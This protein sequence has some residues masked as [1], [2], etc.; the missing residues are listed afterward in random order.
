MDA[1]ADEASARVAHAIDRGVN[2]FDVAPSYG[3]SEERLGPA[4]AP[5][6]KQVFLACKTQKRDKAGAEAEL[7]SSLRRM[8]TDHFDL[9]QL[10]GT[11]ATSARRCSRPLNARGW[12][13]SP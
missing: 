4:L 5:Y 11:P 13:S 2:Y 10:H 1:T 3:N 9:Y 7:D 8:Q 12:A 6:R